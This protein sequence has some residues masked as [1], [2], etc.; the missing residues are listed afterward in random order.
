MEIDRIYIQKKKNIMKKNKKKVNTKVDAEILDSAK[1]TIVH[2]RESEISMTFSIPVKNI[3]KAESDRLIKELKSEWL[4]SSESIPT[5][6][7]DNEE[8]EKEIS[9]LINDYNEEVNWDAENDT[10][11]INGEKISHNKCVY[12]PKLPYQKDICFISKDGSPDMEKLHEQASTMWSKI[13]SK[14]YQQFTIPLHTEYTKEDNLLTK[15]IKWFKKYF[16]K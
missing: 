10:M 11:T 9:R 6:G 8:A 12:I 1:Y 2:D 7:L 5:I 13:N 3:S 4:P 16:T 15:I 14:I